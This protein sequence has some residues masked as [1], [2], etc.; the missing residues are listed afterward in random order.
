MDRPHNSIMVIFGASGDLTK[1]KLIPSIF[2]LYKQGLLCDDFAILGVGRTQF[3]DDQFRQNMFDA[4]LKYS[5]AKDIDKAIL[6]NFVL[7]AYYLPIN[8]EDVNDYRYLKEKLIELN[9]LKVTHGNFIYYLATPPKLYETIVTNLGVYNLQNT[10][11]EHG[12][13]KIIIEKPLD[14]ILILQEN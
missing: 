7:N 4:V 8:T 1:K 11:G 2:E 9:S 13:K 6:K 3:T 12:S 10:P 14:M 5:E